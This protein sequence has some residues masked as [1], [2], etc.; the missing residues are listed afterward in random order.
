[1]PANYGNE[2][3]TNKNNKIYTAI[4]ESALYILMFYV[5]RNLSTLNNY[6]QMTQK[7]RM[8]SRSKL[9]FSLYRENVVFR[10]YTFDIGAYF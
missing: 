9:H 2:T 3:N 4:F 7:K 5:W 6:F 1:M 8:I 10:L